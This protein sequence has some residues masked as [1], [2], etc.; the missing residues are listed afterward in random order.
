MA[1]QNRKR[2]PRRQSSRSSAPI[3]YDDY[4]DATGDTDFEADDYSDED[5]LELEEDQFEKFRKRAQALPIKEVKNRNRRTV[6]TRKPFV[7]GPDYGF[8]PAI[9]IQAPTYVDRLRL[10]QILKDPDQLSSIDV[11]RLIFKDDLNRFIMA[12][13]DA[14]DAEMIALGVIVA[15]FEHFYGKGL[16]EKISDFSTLLL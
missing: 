3:D 4:D 14:E 2:Q 6:H 16:V 8:D 7:L 9:K 13:N 15:Y 11:L 1:N 5:P 12:I 10:E